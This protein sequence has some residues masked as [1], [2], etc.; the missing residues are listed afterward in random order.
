MSRLFRYIFCLLW[1]LGW[2]RLLDAQEQVISIEYFG[3]DKGLNITTLYDIYQDHVGFLWLA[4]REGLVRYDGHAFRY[5]QHDAADS[6][7]I[8][9]NNVACIKEDAVGNIWAGLVRGGV[10]VYNRK[11]GRFRNFPFTEKLKRK[12]ASVTRIFFDRDGGIWM[13]VTGQGIVQLDTINGTIQSHDL[14]T[15]ENAAF[16]T[17]EELSDFNVG[18]NF[19]QDEEGRI[20]CATNADLYVFDPRTGQVESHREEEIKPGTLN[21]GQAYTLFPEGDQLWV[22]GWASGLRRYNRKS[23]EWK[24]FLY[25]QQGPNFDAVNIVNSI[26]HK[27]EDEFWIAGQDRGLGIFNKKTAQFTFFTDQRFKTIGIPSEQLTNL[28][29]DKQGN[30]WGNHNNRLLRIQIK[31]SG[32]QFHAL[33][34]G[35]FGPGAPFVSEVLDD[36]ISKF[37]LI[38]VFGGDGLQV[39]DELTG[40]MTLGKFPVKTAADIEQKL[41]MDLWQGQDNRIWVLG[42]HALYRLDLITHTLEL[43]RQPPLYSSE[44]GSNLYTQITED[45]QG[46]LWMGSSLFGVF[47]YHPG[48]GETTHFMPNE[49]VEGAIA[50]N[51]VG[52]VTADGWGRTWFGSRDK[53]IYGYYLPGKDRF[54]YLDAE[55]QVTTDVASVRMNSFFTDHHGDIWACT[56][57]GL[58]H[59][60]CE[61]EP[62]QLVKKY[63]I[64]DGLSSDYVAWGTEDQRGQIWVTLAAVG[65]CRLEQE[66]DRITTF[67]KVNGVPEQITGIGALSDGRLVLNATGG[68]YTFDPD[69]LTPTELSAPLALTSFKIDDRE[70]YLG[71]EQQIKQPLVVPANSH[72]FSLEFTALNLSNPELCRY[73]YQL[74]GF[75]E[76]WI[77]AGQRHFVNYTNIPKGNYVFRV[78][79]AGMPDVEAL[80]IPLVVNE[81]FYRLWW[82]RLLL[83]AVALGLTFHYYRNRQRHRQQLAQLE[84]KAN[85]LEKE[86][87]LVQYESLKQQLNPHF[88]FNSLSSLGSLISIDPKAAGGFLDSLSKTYRYILKS[89]EREVVPLSEE[90]K[91]AEAFLR[92]QKTRFEEGLQVNFQIEEEALYL[93]I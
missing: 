1:L 89:S 69:S 43:P 51:V 45:R 30:L 3:E 12:T 81:A 49:E 77:S 84:S 52:S 48:S 13:G 31:T 41:I 44:V 70:Y 93:K 75:D 63:T 10:S 56:E 9:S 19:W 54:Y 67:G 65:L 53:T 4:T 42:R 74:Q 55:G 14:V 86:K 17:A 88:L 36:E 16:V 91:S 46:D 37:R 90:L 21:T 92:L 26:V 87:A 72:F 2:A 82:F 79:Q 24:K 50:T 28:C 78:K 38:G 35:K 59:F 32:F 8:R 25:D 23:G 20:W 66:S 22:G 76:H 29:V 58:L 83:T 71:S 18:Y 85:L 62:P 33:R 80:V 27:N 40:A 11:T 47:R 60:N 39:H 64:A 15:T 34:S 6:T 5:F 73:E 61:T 57:Q 68:Y 7:S